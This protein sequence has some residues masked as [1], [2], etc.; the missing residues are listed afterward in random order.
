MSTLPPLIL[1]APLLW[2]ALTALCSVAFQLPA[3]SLVWLNPLTAALVILMLK[4]LG[5]PPFPQL[6]KAPVSVASQ[7]LIAILLGMGAVIMGSELNNILINSGPLE[8]LAHPPKSLQERTLP[9][10]HESGLIY[11]SWALSLAFLLYRRVS[12]H[13]RALKS[14]DQII[15]LSVYGALLSWLPLE[16]GLCLSVASAFLIQRGARWW[17]GTVPFLVAAAVELVLLGG[18]QF[19]ISGFDQV[20]VG[21]YNWHPPW[22]NLLGVV[23]IMTGAFLLEKLFPPRDDRRLLAAALIAEL[24]R[25]KKRRHGR[26]PHRHGEGSDHHDR[27]GNAEPTHER[28]HRPDQRRDDAQEL[29][30]KNRDP[31]RSDSEKHR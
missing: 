16:Q 7:L 21:I 2:Q 11:L 19:K 13:L 5:S 10:L 20:E 22:F 9:S 26:S 17:I 29:Q 28:E 12:L 18:I 8:S 31:E 14:R 1:I 24:H 3:W 15:M 27:E 4:R 23:L 6:H 25:I 30:E